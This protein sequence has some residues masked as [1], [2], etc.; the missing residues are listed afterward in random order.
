MLVQTEMSSNVKV[1]DAVSCVGNFIEF[2]CRKLNEDDDLNYTVSRESMEARKNAFTI[3]TSAANHAKHLPDKKREVNNKARLY[4][5]IIEWFSSMNV[6]FS[7]VNRDTLGVGLVNALTDALW[8]ID[9]NHDTLAERSCPV[10]APLALFKNFYCVCE[11]HEF[12]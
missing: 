11:C 3:L 2:V 4:N 7:S 8:Y 6:G 5:D 1:C 9:G 12:F 10:P